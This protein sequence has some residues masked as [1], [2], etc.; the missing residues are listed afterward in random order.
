KRDFELAKTVFGAAISQILFARRGLSPDNFQ[1]LPIQQIIER[2][3]EDIVAS[4]F[5]IRDYDLELVRD[6]TATV[7][8]R[9]TGEY[10]SKYVLGILSTD[11]FPLI[12]SEDL[13]KFRLT[14]LRSNTREEDP[15]IDFF[16]LTPKYELDGKYAIN[17]WRTGTGR[18]RVSQTE[19]KLWNLGD[20]LGR[21]PTIK[22]PHSSTLAVSPMSTRT[23]DSR[24][25]PSLGLWK[26]GREAFNSA[27]RIIKQRNGY[28]NQK[29]A[30]L[31]LV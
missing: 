17:I 21:L 6:S 23:G 31:E 4:G 28:C 10:I 15:L 19:Y 14:F 16:T 18:Q 22:G 3:F 13:T 9:D 24:Q 7:F 29:I 27:K 25:T 2:P 11:I 1:I 5:P 30:R 12:E 20:Y 8:L 26:P